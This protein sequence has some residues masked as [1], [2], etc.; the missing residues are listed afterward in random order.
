[1]KDYAGQIAELLKKGEDVLFYTLGT[2][3]LL[4]IKELK[5]RFGLLPTAVCD[6]DPKKQ[7]RAWK[8]LEGVPVLS[9]DEAFEHFPDARWFIPS[10][11]YRYQIIGY[12][13]E[14]RG[15]SPDRIVNYEPVRKFRSCLH[16]NQSVQYD[17]TGELTFS[18]AKACPRVPAGENPNASALRKLRDELI[19][20]IEEDHIPRDSLCAGCDLIKEDYYPIEPKTLFVDYFRKGVCNYKCSYCSVAHEKKEQDGAGEH[21][22]EE[23]IS[24]LRQE[25]MLGENYT[26]DFVTAGEPT[27]YPGRKEAFKTFD[28]DKMAFVTNGFLFDPDLFELMNRKKVY[29]VCSIDAGTPETYQWIKKVDGFDRVRGNMKKYAQA[30]VGIVV[31]KYILLPGVNDV[32]EEID[33]FINFCVETGA[34]L[35]IE[36]L[37]AYDVDKVTGQTIEMAKKLVRGL[38][39]KDILC[40]PLTANY[41][42]EFA[43]VVRAMAAVEE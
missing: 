42:E 37:D 29:V 1:M 33:G 12:L 38:S 41:S 36:S 6:K 4:S 5:S 25:D 11:N 30:S 40:V 15:I 3:T 26:L 21:T 18:C 32:S 9:P 19:K 8:G 23:V 34:A 13:T 16:L 39:K 35:A 17:C 43:S 24:A 7:G 28:G 14:E 2:D 22:V 20:A 27:L 31:L 10:I